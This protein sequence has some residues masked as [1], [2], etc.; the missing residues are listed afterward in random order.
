V[1][2]PVSQLLA[3]YAVALQLGGA[4]ATIAALVADRSWLARP[5]ATLLL[6]GSIG[7][8]RALPVRLSKYAFLTQTAVPVLAGTLTIGLAP[9]LAALYVGTIA[10]D[11]L[12]LRKSFRSA[13][14]NAGREALVLLAAYGFLAATY[15]LTGRP[16]PGLEVLPALL[17][18][19]LVYLVLGRLLFYC[20]LLVRSKL[21]PIERSLIL[22]WE[23]LSAVLSIGGTLLVAGSL[24]ALTSAGWVAAGLV[25]VVLWALTQ[26]I[27]ADAI[28]AEDHQK[29][30]V[31]ETAVAESAR[32]DVALAAVER[33]AYRLIDWGDFR[34]W[35]YDSTGDRLVY[36][37]SIGRP[38]RDG[39]PPDVAVLR[40]EAY[41][42]GRAA[43]V[44]DASGDARLPVLDADVRSI[45]AVPLRYADQLLGA[46]EV[47]YWKPHHYDTRDIAALGLVA[48]R[49]AVALHIADLRRPLQRTVEQVGT[50]AEGLAGALESLV[51]SAEALAQA[52][53][54]IRRTVG[55]Q[56]AFVAEGLETTTAMAERAEALQ[57]QAARAATASRTAAETADSQRGAIS[58]ALERLLLLKGF[59]ADASAQSARV[60]AA[61]RG[62]AMVLE[63]VREIADTTNVLALNAALE[64]SRAGPEGAGFTVVA[65]EV[66]TL[67]VQTLAAAE[68]AGELVAALGEE[69]AQAAQQMVR[70]EQAV[71]GVERESAAAAEALARLSDAITAVGEAADRIADAALEQVG[72]ADHLAE[73]FGQAAWHA[74]RARQEGESLAGQAH[75]AARGQAQLEAAARELQAVAA[76]L[77][78]LTNVSGEAKA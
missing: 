34:V 35:R 73:R 51:T 18:F 48:A 59:V 13:S 33:V 23:V 69:S 42:T 5:E 22:R 10:A 52:S 55:E 60:G 21:E 45:V 68:R 19:A 36:R 75:A 56:E 50:Q 62:I 46:L 63:E 39:P 2:T 78:A 54:E 49:V 43:H 15:G 31:M 53:I 64:A 57:Q 77:A 26:R 1:R 47:D 28:A 9:V 66:R 65:D 38:R 17:V 6:L 25:L 29:L 12:W 16:G 8:L 67:A 24:R 58:S 74:A 20:S 71:A 14:I 37:G 4:A 3:R 32:I 30:Y 72:S 70:G 11:T 76:Q 27:L 44:R 7:L 40:R 41:A 61:M